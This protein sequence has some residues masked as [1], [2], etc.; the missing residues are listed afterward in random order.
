MPAGGS[1]GLPGGCARGDG[2]APPAPQRSLDIYIYMHVC[3]H[4]YIY[5]Y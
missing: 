4:I 2:R 5:T 3:I 1:P